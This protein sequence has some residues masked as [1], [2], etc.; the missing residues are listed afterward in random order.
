[1]NS[2]SFYDASEQDAGFRRIIVTEPSHPYVGNWW[3]TGHGLGYEHGFTHQVVD[4]VNAIGAGKQPSP[5][6][7]DALQV[8]KVLTAV[9]ASAEAESRWQRV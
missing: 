4:L 7:S 3:P 2:L 1:M 5:S 6:F 9:E 8:Q